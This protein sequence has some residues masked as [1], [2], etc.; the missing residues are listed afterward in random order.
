ME[1]FKEII[2]ILNVSKRVNGH[3]KCNSIKQRKVLKIGYGRN[4]RWVSQNNPL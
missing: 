3:L 4:N 2:H 1:L